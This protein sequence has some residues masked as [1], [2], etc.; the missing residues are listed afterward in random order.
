MGWM[1]RW[2]NSKLWFQ[3]WVGQPD[4]SHLFSPSMW[5]LLP[6]LVHPMSQGTR[7]VLMPSGLAHPHVEHQGQLYCVSQACCRACSPEGAAGIYYYWRHMW[8]Y[9]ANQFFMRF[10]SSIFHYISLYLKQFWYDFKWEGIW[11]ILCSHLLQ[12]I[13][14]QTLTIVLQLGDKTHKKGIRMQDCFF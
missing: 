9:S 5:A 12:S 7:P 10:I 14:W 1:L 2:A 3:A 13:W 11:L 6:Q 8:F 4:N